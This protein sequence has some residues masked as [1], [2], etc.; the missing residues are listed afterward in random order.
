MAPLS[1]LVSYGIDVFP[2]QVQ[3]CLLPLLLERFVQALDSPE[4][5]PHPSRGDLEGCSLDY[6]PAMHFPLTIPCPL[7]HTCT[8]AVPGM[9]VSVSMLPLLPSLQ[10][11]ELLE[12][13]SQ[14]GSEGIDV[15]SLADV[16]PRLTAAV[17]SKQFGQEGILCPLI[18]EVSGGKGL[19]SRE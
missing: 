18:A 6:L 8:L 4:S 1:V 14:P 13:L 9:I 12:S 3:L 10:A 11:L 15:R 7:M 5:L 16:T 2:K 19:P 17:G